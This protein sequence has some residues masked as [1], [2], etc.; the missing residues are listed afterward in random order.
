M[1]PPRQRTNRGSFCLGRRSRDQPQTSRGVAASSAGSHQTLLFL[2]LFRLADLADFLQGY[3][4]SANETLRYLGTEQAGGKFWS[5]YFQDDWKVRSNL[6]LNVGL[7][8][9]FRGFPFDKRDNFVTFVPTGPA[10]SNPG[11]GLLVSAL[12]NAENDALCNSPQYSFLVSPATGNCLL[13]N[14]VQRA[15]MG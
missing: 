1:R 10:W 8:Y 14:S 2:A 4:V 7:R 11:N 13:A 5:Y 6:T 9:E 15:A 12:P 3:P